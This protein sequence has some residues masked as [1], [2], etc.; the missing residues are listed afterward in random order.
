MPTPSTVHTIKP[1]QH[2]CGGFFLVSEAPDFEGWRDVAIRF[3]QIIKKVYSRT[4]GSTLET[5]Q[6]YRGLS[7]GQRGESYAVKYL[8][9]NGYQIIALRERDHRGE[10][11]I[12][13]NQPADD[14]MVFVEVKTLQSPKPGHPAERV[15][16]RKQR[17]ITDA[18]L[19]YLKRN[20]RLDTKVRFDV[21]AIRWPHDAKEPSE[22]NHFISAF[23]AANEYQFY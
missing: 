15:D 8:R 22:I 21:I 9:Q 19:R 7:I 1:S 12:I 16:G 10:I 17:R 2:R 4:Q 11:D 5:N 23:E 14:T 3:M 13:A 6:S 18:A 20:H